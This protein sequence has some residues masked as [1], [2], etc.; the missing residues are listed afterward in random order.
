MVSRAMVSRAMVSRARVSRAMVSIARVS[1]ARVSIA[2]VSSIARP[3]PALAAHR[4][5]DLHLPCEYRAL[6]TMVSIAA[7]SSVA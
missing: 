2:R 6:L 3:G 5:V 7:V 4:Y 1:I